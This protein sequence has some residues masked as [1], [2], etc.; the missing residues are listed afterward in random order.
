M[1][2][3]S[4][5]ALGF[6]SI[7]HEMVGRGVVGLNAITNT[8]EIVGVPGHVFKV[9]ASGTVDGRNMSV[10]SML[11]RLNP[12]DRQYVTVVVRNREIRD[13]GIDWTLTTADTPCLIRLGDLA[14][15]IAQ[16]GT[17]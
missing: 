6:R 16:R 5:R 13:P 14:D 2:L 10:F 9:V 8:R 7:F 17:R 15:L 3:K 1:V 11:M 12:P 4:K